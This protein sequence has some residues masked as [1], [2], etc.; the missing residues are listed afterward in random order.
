MQFEIRINQEAFIPL[1]VIFDNPH[2]IWGP[3]Y[4]YFVNGEEVTRERFKEIKRAWDK[5]MARRA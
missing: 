3:D 2:F 1:D 4:S 5:V